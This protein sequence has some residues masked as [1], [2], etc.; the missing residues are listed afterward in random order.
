SVSPPD[1]SLPDWIEVVEHNIKVVQ[2]EPGGSYTF[3]A[4]FRITRDAPEGY[5]LT[6]QVLVSF[7][8][9]NEAPT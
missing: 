1:L 3:C 5:E 4:T 2:I 7:V 8:Q 9:W 6:G